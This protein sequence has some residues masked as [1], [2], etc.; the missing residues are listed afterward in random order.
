MKDKLIK[1]KRSR[2]N[3]IELELI[4]LL[5]VLTI[6]EQSLYTE[7]IFWVYGDNIV[8]EQNTKDKILLVNSHI[9]KILMQ[10]KGSVRPLSIIRN[11]ISDV[12]G[13][14]IRSMKLWYNKKEIFD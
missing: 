9:F 5:I 12:D 14:S 2:I 13:Y 6:K 10:L 8:I 1:I 3:P 7:S 4:D 11:F